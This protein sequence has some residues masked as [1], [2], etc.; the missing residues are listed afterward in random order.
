MYVSVYWFRFDYNLI[1]FVCYP[2][3]MKFVL[4]LLLFSVFCVATKLFIE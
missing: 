4:I 2:F 3:L 1:K